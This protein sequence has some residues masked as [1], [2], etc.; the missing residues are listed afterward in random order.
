M[1]PL[2]VYA[3]TWTKWAAMSI[4]TSNDEGGVFLSWTRADAARQGVLG[5][6]VEALKSAGV[7]VWIDD[8]QIGAFDSIPERCGRG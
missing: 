6:L 1:P 8:G 4:S 2:T 7:P 3:T 5:R